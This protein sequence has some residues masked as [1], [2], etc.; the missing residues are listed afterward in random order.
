MGDQ[1]I[2]ETFLPENTK[3]ERRGMI[4]RQEQALKMWVK[5]KLP[6]LYEKIAEIM[7]RAMEWVCNEKENAV[8]ESL[9]KVYQRIHRRVTS[10]S[11]PTS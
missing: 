11:S 8:I 2:D 4:I 5:M 1:N 3:K 7:W 9:K 10:A 6:F